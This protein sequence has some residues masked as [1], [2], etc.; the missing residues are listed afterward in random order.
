MNP[1]T[2]KYTPIQ[3][4]D[5][6]RY[7]KMS[8]SPMFFKGIKDKHF[9]DDYGIFDSNEFIRPS[10]EWRE[11]YHFYDEFLNN[12]SSW[13]SWPKRNKSIIGTTSLEVAQLYALLGGKGSKVYIVIP[14]KSRTILC[15]TDDILTSFNRGPG[16]TLLRE[17]SHSLLKQFNE[18]FLTFLNR[19]G[20]QEE[21]IR[22][23]DFEGMI[24]VLKNE[25]DNKSLTDLDILNHV[26]QS[27]NILQTFENLFDPVKNN[28]SL[29]EK[30]DLCE[31]GEGKEVFS[32]GQVLLCSYEKAKGLGIYP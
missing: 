9:K 28:F 32:S 27:G 15:P 11:N 20:Y 26:Y 2:I 13:E 3:Q 29:T 31:M 12:L 4:T 22:K 8:S 24:Q 10:K 14:L 30:V 1:R 25:V 16:M 5:F 19:R 21:K 7:Y 18:E 23:L 17:D 6:V